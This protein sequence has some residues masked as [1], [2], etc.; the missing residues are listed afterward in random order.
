[1]TEVG[2]ANESSMRHPD[3][4]NTAQTKC[5]T[6]HGSALAIKERLNDWFG[7]AWAFQKMT[8]IPRA[9]ARIATR[10]WNLEDHDDSRARVKEVAMAKVIEFYIPQNFRRT[11]KWVPDVQRGKILELRPQTKKSA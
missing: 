10:S 5:K 11:T 7:F 6:K 4:E 2:Q 1:M 9:I 3:G 8:G